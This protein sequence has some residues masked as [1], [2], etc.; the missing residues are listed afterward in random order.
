MVFQILEHFEPK[1]MY[2]CVLQLFNS[3]KR[4]ENQ[5]ITSLCFTNW[6]EIEI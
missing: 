4:T 3:N 5:E 2:L 6:M 1:Y